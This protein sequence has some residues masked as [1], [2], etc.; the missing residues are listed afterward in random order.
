MIALQ[1]PYAPRPIRPLGLW[2]AAGWRLKQYGIAH[3]GERPRPQLV[4][5]ARAAVQRALPR[6]A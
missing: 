1:E 3:Q 2:E 4:T 5:G 6:L